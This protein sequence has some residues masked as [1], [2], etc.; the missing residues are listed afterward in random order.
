MDKE[1]FRGQIAFITGSNRGLGKAIAIAFAK[2]GSNLIMHSRSDT[3]EFESFVSDL[4]MQFKIK[5]RKVFFD[6]RDHETMKASVRELHQQKLYC[7]ILVNSAGVPAG[8]LFQMTSME[9]IRDVFE[10]NLFSQMELTQLLLRP[11][12]KRKHG[13]IINL[14]SISGQDLHAGNSAYGASKAALSAFTRTLAAETGSLGVRV[15]A[16]APSLC[17]TQMAK[18]MENNAASHMISSSAMK[19]LCKPE[20]VAS[21]VTFLASSD[22]TFINGQILRVD[23]GMA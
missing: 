19:R 16:V 13:C 1:E 14:C 20:E 6:L 18:Q 17:D 11:M 3:P 7:D 8:G 2:L 12:I 5:V 21:V 10:I 22:A 23:G 4:E 9:S 15:N